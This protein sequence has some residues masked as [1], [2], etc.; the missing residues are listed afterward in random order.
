M[1]NFLELIEKESLF[2]DCNFLYE[3]PECGFK[4]TKTKAYVKKRLEEMGIEAFDCGKCGVTATIGKGSKCLLLR[5]DM[6]AIDLDGKGA[7]HGCGHHMHTA[8]LLGAASLIKK[9]EHK[10][11]NTI[12]LMFQPAE[13]ILEGAKDMIACG[14]LENPVPRAAFMLHVATGVDLPCGT[15]VFPESGTIAPAAVYFDVDILGKGC[16][17]SQ[18]SH[19]IDPII[20]GAHVVT[21]IDNIVSKEISREERAV[22]TV[23]SFHSG[24]ASNAIASKAVIGGTFRSFSG[25]TMEFIKERLTC[26]SHNICQ[27][28]R[29]HGRLTFRAE[30][31]PLVNDAGVRERTLSLAK[32][33]FESD[34][35]LDASNLPS[36]EKGAGSEDFAYVSQKIPA[37]MVSLV[38][39]SKADGYNYPLHH[40]EVRFDK[41]ALPF[42]SAL[43]AYWALNF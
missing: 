8:M 19:G 37:V 34:M 38:A 18:P 1:N 10:L 22:I 15:V 11:T 3:N 41:N 12:K 39:G 32:E 31:P 14:V 40:P 17:G 21:A 16:H 43:M 29:A 2:A 23:G 36:A 25:K 35:I 7:F 6:D 26:I 30:C 5:A 33:L 4:L 24:K 28:F 27:G 20:A 9:M 42:G 13:E